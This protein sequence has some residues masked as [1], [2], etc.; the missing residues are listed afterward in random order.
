MVKNIETT[1]VISKGKSA[2]GV[3]EGDEAGEVLFVG[4]LEGDFAFALAVAGEGD[5]GVEGG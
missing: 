1:I 3:E 2:E 5:G 4:E